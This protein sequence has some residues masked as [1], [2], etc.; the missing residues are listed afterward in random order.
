MEEYLNTSY[1]PDC[2]YVDGKVL[3][4]NVGEREHSELQGELTF[5]LGGF[6]KER[7]FH[8]FIA[9]RMQTLPTRFRIPDICV[10]LG[11]RPSTAIFVEPPFLCI[12]IL[13]KDDRYSALREK[14]ADYQSFGVKY[15]WVIDPSTRKADIY[16]PDGCHEAKD[17]ILS[18]S[19]PEISVSLPELY[20]SLE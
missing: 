18:T 20:R 15:V 12:E 5:Y 7:G 9:Q 17:G 2:D 11:K 13:S 3:E 4:R 6:R 19:D 10:V 14:I 8:I 16:G 1:D